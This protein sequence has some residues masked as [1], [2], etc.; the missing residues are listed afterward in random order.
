MKIFYIT[1]NTPDEAKAISFDLLERRYAVCTNWFPIACAYRWEGEI[2]QTQEVVLIIKTQ[3]GFREAIEKVVA[4]HIQYT[5]F[6]A[7]IDIHSIN[8]NFLTWLNAEVPHI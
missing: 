3:T 2:K 7:E 5:N 6:M 8:S 4:E 1:L